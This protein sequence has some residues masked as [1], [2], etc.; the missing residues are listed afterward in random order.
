M[1]RPMPEMDSCVTKKNG[2]DIHGLDSI[3]GDRVCSI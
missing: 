1:L 3:A 2:H